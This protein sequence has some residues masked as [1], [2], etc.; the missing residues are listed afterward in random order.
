VLED[1]VRT[2][3]T[4]GRGGR[5][6]PHRHHRGGAA[7]P[8][9]AAGGPNL[10]A[11]KAAAT[12]SS[13]GPYVAA[14]IT[15][16]NP[17]VYRES[18]DNAFQQWAQADLG[19]IQAIDQVKLKLPPSWEARTQ[20][21]SVQGSANGSSFTTLVPS[22]AYT[23][24][25]VT[26]NAVTIN[27]SGT[28]R[29]LRLNIT[30]NTGWPAGQL[31]ELEV[32]G[33]GGGGDTQPPTAPGNLAFTQ[34][35]ADQ[36]RLSWT[37]SIDNVGVAGYDIFANGSLRSSVSPTTLTY[38]DTQPPSATV[39]Y[40]V[41]ARDAAGNESPESNP[42]TRTGTGG[43]SN[44]AVGK[45]IEAS[46]IVHVLKAE[47]ANDDDTSTYWE[48]SP[49][50]YPS[51]LTVNLGANASVTSV[52]LKLNPDPIWGPRTQTL[53]VL[54]REQSAAG[55]TTIKPS[56]TYGFNPGSG[57]TATIAISADVADVRLQF[58]ANTGASNGQ[59]AEFQVIG[60][61]APN[62]DLTI[63]ATS[64][65]PAAPTETDA[66]SVSATVRN[67]G[68][69]ASG[70]T[71]VNFYLGATRVGTAA[72]GG[73]AAG[74]SSTVT[75]SIGSRDAGSY[76]LSGKVD[77]ANTVIEQNDTN[78]S[79]THPAPLTVRPVESSDL[80]AAAGS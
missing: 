44:L 52:V 29:H 3:E 16:G 31:S 58:T 68:T 14:N 53:E 20:T 74:G 72:V 65:A 61:P 78:N 1:H 41:R 21:L 35:L 8:A 39:T 25:P 2:I 73:L 76:Q 42:V 12:T 60:T 9:Q 30:A 63:P 6:Q 22:A 47:N 24:N 11:G 54:G 57:N 69:R 19:T 32:Y 37:A 13:N 79:H 17:N 36:I 28:T 50:A 48:G 4:A 5:D 51:T 80:V 7:R 34:P 46:S 10:A 26:G 33:P 49:G 62:P 43:G 75:A 59:V 55:F 77:E 71:N 45:P 27:L 64:F 23:F 40:P 15:E 38:T 66:I 18:A 67:A 70:A 56:A